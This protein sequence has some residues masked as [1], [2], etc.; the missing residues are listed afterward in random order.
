MEVDIISILLVKKLSL[1]DVKE[2]DKSHTARKWQKTLS[3]L[4]NP[5][6]EAS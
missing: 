3:G 5:S 6:F 4:L 1:R 2:I